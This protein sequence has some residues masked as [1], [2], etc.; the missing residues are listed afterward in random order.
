MTRNHF[1]NILQNLNYSDSQTADKSD[2]AYN[3]HSN[4]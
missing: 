3:M 4:A 2:K 1:I